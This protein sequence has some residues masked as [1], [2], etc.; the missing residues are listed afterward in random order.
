MDQA[1]YKVMSAKKKLDI[2]RA[3]TYRMANRSE[4]NLVKISERATRVT[5]ACIERAIVAGKAKS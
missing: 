3:T 4:L 1:L 5:A 2:C